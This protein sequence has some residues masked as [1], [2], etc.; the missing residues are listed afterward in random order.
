MVSRVLK[1]QR[2]VRGWR[3][4]RKG[5]SRLW[6]HRENCAN[7]IKGSYFIWQARKLLRILRAEHAQRCV[8]KVQCVYRMRL[9]RMKVC[10]ARLKFLNMMA[11]KICR[12]SR[13]YLGRRRFKALRL[14]SQIILKE[15]TTQIMSDIKLCKGGIR[16]TLESIGDT[17]TFSEWDYLDCALFN[18]LGVNRR[19]FA[20]DIAVELVRRFP[21][22]AIGRFV[23]ECVLFLTWTCSGKNQHVREDYLEELIGILYHNKFLNEE[24]EGIIDEK[25]PNS[26]RTADLFS[27]FDVIVKA[28]PRERIADKTSH[29]A[30]TMDEIEFM[31]FRNA[32]FRHGRSNVALASMAACALLR[33]PPQMFGGDPEN[34]KEH[35]LAVVRARKLLLRSQLINSAGLT[36]ATSRLEIMN[37][38]FA[39]PHRVIDTKRLIFTR[40]RLFGLE[41]FMQLHQQTRLN[42][43]DGLA[44][45]I[46]IVQCTS[47]IFLVRAASVLLPMTNQE[48]DVIRRRNHDVQQLTDMNPK[49]VINYDDNSSLRPSKYHV[50][51]IILQKSEVKHLTD[52]AILR[53][54]SASNTLDEG[55]KLS[56][57]TQILSD[58]ILEELRLVSCRSRLVYSSDQHE[59]C[60]LRLVLP[61]LEYARRE[62]N[63]LRTTQYSIKTIQRIFR[64]FCGKS[65]F[66]RLLTRSLESTRQ[67]SL[68][69]Q[70]ITKLSEIRQQ[71]NYFAGKIQAKVRRFLWRRLMKKLHRAALGIQCCFRIKLARKIV[72]NRRRRRDMGPEVVEMLR[73]GVTVGS[74]S[75][76]LIIYR[77]G[78]NYRMAGHDMVNNAVYEGSLHR[79]DVIRLVEEHNRDTRQ[80]MYIYN[81]HRVSELI[82]S[83]LGVATSISAV[84][85]PLGAI[86][87]GL[88]R[89]CLVAIPTASP[90]KNNI[91]CISGL[92][93]GLKDQSAALERYQKLSSAKIRGLKSRAS[94][95]K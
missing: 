42:L 82:A 76:T 39:M 5:L 73:K 92:N 24:A 34:K 7:R 61:A 3:G 90:E 14:R 30:S 94:S 35:R 95:L 1:M 22:F 88:K 43:K 2:V 58:I 37:G 33:L 8:L 41:G 86:S 69:N 15:M 64:G 13:G 9:A 63:N 84:T 44:A 26:L 40:C 54:A 11:L 70:R 74:L 89:L 51:P 27:S 46:E 72:S 25:G 75:F 18:L 68:F 31:Y 29:F 32:F 87:P 23:L 93:R 20:L 21:E 10:S 55:M 52:L 45:V 66:R 48:I 80:K 78:D 6:F 71:R 17:S 19:D 57:T 16:I 65:R 81:Y 56:G 38:V 59:V 60:S 12:V 62:R 4:R 53:N 28:M 50:R 85:T 47:D 49:F 77:C 91:E 79:P 36:E 83:R 67:K